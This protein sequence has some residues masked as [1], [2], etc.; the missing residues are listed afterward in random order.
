MGAIPISVQSG[1]LIAR[2]RNKVHDLFL[3]E[4]DADYLLWTDSDIIFTSED[5][6]HLAE[7]DADIVSGL[8]YG[9][10]NDGQ[11]FPVYTQQGPKNILYR[12]QEPPGGMGEVFG[13][14]M[15]FCLI[16]RDVIESLT[17]VWALYPFAE[18]AYGKQR[19]VGEDVAFCIRARKKGWR[20]WLDPSVRVGHK[21][22]VV[23]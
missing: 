19:A 18:M 10:D 17:P 21:K 23:L 4:T 20:V 2:A 12:P 7:H 16:R 6:T 5:V 22:D 8:Y 11:V 13:I 14:G 1:P 3:T 15:G 9:K